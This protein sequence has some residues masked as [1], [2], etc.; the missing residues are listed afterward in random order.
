MSRPRRL[1][2][3]SFLG[4]YRYFLTTCTFDR[5]RTFGSHEHAVG[6]I[7]QF[8][9]TAHRQEFAVLAYCLMPDHLHVLA[10]GKGDGS[11][12][13]RFVKLAKQRSGA[14]YALRTGEPLWQKGYHERV[15]RQ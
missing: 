15:L 9:T 3:F 4:R 14:N 5:R 12:F 11:D 1:D 2:G 8:L 10:E 13:R 7:D 6:T